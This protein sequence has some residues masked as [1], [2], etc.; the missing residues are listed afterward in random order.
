MTDLIAVY[1]FASLFTACLGLVVWSG[2]TAWSAPR[3][4]QGAR[5]ILLCWA[6]PVLLAVAF[7]WAVRLLLID[8]GW[9]K[10]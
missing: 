8:A 10:G 3:K 1:V 7:I 5:V 6:W 9:K 2:A 4:Q